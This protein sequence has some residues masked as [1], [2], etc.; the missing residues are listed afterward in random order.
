MAVAGAV[1]L[2]LAGGHPSTLGV[3]RPAPPPEQGLSSLPSATQAAISGALGADSP[4]YRVSA[5]NGAFHAL[6]PTQ[7]LSAGFDR[8]GL[9][10]SS[11]ALGLALSLRAVR[12]GASLKAVRA[13]SPSVSANRVSYSY[14]DLS[15]WFLNGPLGLEQ[16]FTIPRA[17][18][19][20][21]AGPLTLSMA[22][23]GDARASLSTGG[24]SITLSHAGARSLRYGELI[25]TDATGR[26][27]HSS[28]ALAGGNIL[29]RIDTKGARYPLRIDPLIQQGEKLTGAGEEGEGRFGASVALSADGDTALIGAPRDQGFAGAA[30]VFTRSGSTWTQQGPKLTGNEPGVE[31]GE[32]ECAEETGEEPGG[33]AFGR[34]VALSADG[35]TAVIGGP[36]ADDHQGAAWVFTRSGSTWTQQGG[37]LTG[38]EERGAGHFGRSVALSADG[39][40]AL[41]G[42]GADRAA[43]GAA[44]V[45]TRSG[46]TW[47]QQG[48]KLAGGEE[49]GEGRFGASVALSSD[50]DTALIGGPGD[51][52]HLGAAWVFTR[53]GT[54]WTQQGAKLTGGEELGEGRFGYS[55]ALSGEGDTALIG[56]RSDSEDAGAAWAF[57]RSGSKWA[58]QGP[59][60][61]SGE[62]SDARRFGYSVALSGD[63]S[64]ALVG[65]PRG[66]SHLATAWVFT[67]SGAT[68][69]QQPE[70]LA[71]AEESAKGSFGASV[72]L[73]AD[74]DTVLIGAPSE[75]TRAGAAWAF[76]SE[77]APTLTPTVTK[78][79]PAS[80]PAGG[81]TTVSIS[82]ADFTAATAVDF[83]AVSAVSFTVNSADSITAVS[84]AEPAGT[85][86]VTVTTPAGTSSTAASDHFKFLASTRAEPEP[87]PT[88]MEV[89]VSGNG[90]STVAT[91]SG[92]VLGF[93]ALSATT[94]ATCKVSLVSRRITV[95][96]H[97]W[98]AL[99]LRGTG[100]GKCVGK[101]T[102]TVKRKTSSKRSKTS[103][104]AAASFSIS[105][106][107]TRIVKVKLDAA[108]RALLRAGHGRLNASLAILKWSPAPV[109]A[110]TASVHLNV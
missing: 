25:A 103:S 11:G 58:Q 91:A 9:Q 1:W 35:N 5:W 106:G 87:E 54:E 110:Q 73:S 17:P 22:L 24:H 56:G 92:G 46:T 4:A 88:P 31:A 27:L 29:V 72:A 80:G 23:S 21:R 40:T 32:E 93:R 63:G 96:G 13:A 67:R 61:T 33:C 28:L 74:G 52:G 66:D 79:A 42:G 81:A 15:E 7:R 62:E 97:S 68:W 108:G 82:G 85:V 34:S 69:T 18:S 30:W 70:A 89:F 12:Y 57:T 53:T 8:S 14:P 47:T 51:T 26:V 38:G 39:D 3:V 45:F 101:L 99:K 94:P 16:G 65:G 77:P 48:P 36:R 104:I 19:A 75:N 86:D 44:W 64:T 100:S 105:P 20:Q 102:L 60:L 78:V 98:A 90:E 6:N 2:G 37:E 59:K 49:S 55:V 50:G 41:I 84:P 83:G 10:L 71:G 109:K 43:R 95:Q 107:K 76:V